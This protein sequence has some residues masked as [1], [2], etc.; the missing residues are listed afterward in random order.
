MLAPTG[1]RLVRE[2]GWL[3]RR[4][5]A[6]LV[7][8]CTPADGALWQAAL[9][10][11]QAALAEPCWQGAPLTL[12]LSDRLLHYQLL[13]WQP[14]LGSLA[15]KQGYARFHFQQVY[16]PRVEDWEIRVNDT[17]PGMPVVACAVDR[18]L[19]SALEAVAKTAGTR[20]GS[21]QPAFAVVFNRLRRF[22]PTAPGATAVLALAEPGGLCYAL[23]TGGSWQA[24]RQRS[25]AA[26]PAA[27]PGEILRQ[28]LAQERLMADAPFTEAAVYSV[29][30][31]DEGDE[32][33][34]STWRMRRLVM[35]KE[36]PEWS[37]PA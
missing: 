1:I 7:L 5:I 25:L 29:A 26:D 13:P 2:G 14:A 11:L 27:D 22:L 33:L 12:M 37:D 32:E 17:A 6:R 24:L 20:L 15:E 23:L 19:T 28:A 10:T 21:I 35:K 18:A 4:C 31:D 9:A 36:L 30:H 16:G 3:K 34:G 8:P